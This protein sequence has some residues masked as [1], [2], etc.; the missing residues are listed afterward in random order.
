MEG[1][2]AA[3]RRTLSAL[4]DD[5]ELTKQNLNASVLASLKLD[6]FCLELVQKGFEPAVEITRDI[7]AASDKIQQNQFRVFMTLIF[8]AAG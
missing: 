3:G 1:R 7:H 6:T 5:I 4:L 2:V 8:I